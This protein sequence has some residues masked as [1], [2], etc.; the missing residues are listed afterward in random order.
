MIPDNLLG[1][2]L[3]SEKS[4]ESAVEVFRKGQYWRKSKL[5]TR[6]TE[7]LDVSWMEDLDS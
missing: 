5:T 7:N 3:P 6:L 2:L 4:A 1:K